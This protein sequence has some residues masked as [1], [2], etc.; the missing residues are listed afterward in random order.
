M[1]SG[2]SRLAELVILLADK[3]PESPLYFMPPQHDTPAS[4]PQGRIRE[5]L[6]RNILVKFRESLISQSR[7]SV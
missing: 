2:R 3:R 5:N 6:G 4:A 1:S 7:M